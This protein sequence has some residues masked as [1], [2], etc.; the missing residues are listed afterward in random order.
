MVNIKHTAGQLNA[1]QLQELN[2]FFV[3]N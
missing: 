1:A 2:Q 3:V